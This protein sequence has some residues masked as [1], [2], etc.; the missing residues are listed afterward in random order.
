MNQDM[1][2]AGVQDARNHEYDQCLLFAATVHQLQKP[3]VSNSVDQSKRIY[4]LGAQ[5]LH[6]IGSGQLCEVGVEN[7]VV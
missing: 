5:I 3:W 1:R 2:E 4:I 7:A 6:N